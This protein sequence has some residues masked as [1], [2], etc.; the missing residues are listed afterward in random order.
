MNQINNDTIIALATSAGVGA[1]AV[2]RL[3]GENAIKIV[4]EH[5]KSKF[6]TETI[7]YCVLSLI[8]K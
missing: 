1:I 5:F 2:M 8:N 3:S 7:Y 6:G 4:N